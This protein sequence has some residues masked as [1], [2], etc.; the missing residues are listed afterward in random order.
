MKLYY[1]E[2]P[3]SRKACAVARYLD[4]SAELVRVDLGKGEN[5]T[6]EFLAINPNGKLPA[7]TDGETRLWEGHAIMVHLAQKAGSDLW[8]KEPNKQVDVLRWLN[9]DT[10]HFSRHAG[11]L[12]FENVIKAMFSMGPA[13]PAVVEEASGFFKQF[14]AVLDG[15]LKGK[16]WL[17]GDQL[18]VA[19]FGVAASLPDAAAAKLPL[20]GFGEIERWHNSLMDLPAW[21]EAFPS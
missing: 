11:T 5:K 13:D 9:W 15:E 18:T 16:K 6:P 8:P 21:R 10:A 3:N 14:A 12:L 19:D 2:T 7:L 1:F 17:L 4:S 20:Q